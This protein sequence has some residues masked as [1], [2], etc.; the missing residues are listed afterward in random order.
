MDDRVDRVRDLLHEA[1][2][3]HHVVFRL[4]DGDDPDWATWYTAWLVDHSELPEVLGARPVPSELTWL[5]VQADKDV[6]AEPSDAAWEDVYAA[7]IV[8]HFG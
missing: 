4:T 1:G 8:E 2:A 3:T 5:L 6:T 7:R